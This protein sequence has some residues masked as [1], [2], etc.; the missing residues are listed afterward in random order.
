MSDARFLDICVATKCGESSNPW[1][2]VGAGRRC[3]LTSA[4]CCRSA[5]A[6]RRMS[7]LHGRA[8][9]PRS[10]SA[11]RYAHERP[12]DPMGMMLH[13]FR[14]R[15]K[16]SE[17]SKWAGLYDYP[18]EVELIAG[19]VARSRSRGYLTREDFLDIAEWKSARPRKH[20]QANQPAFI[21]EFSRL[22]FAPSASPRLAIEP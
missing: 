16:R 15:F 10:R 17:I 8:A 3:H 11:M 19:P 5:A 1:L 9:A 18:G 13:R 14:P 2:L 22:A 6:N 12:L 20:Y 21:E 7:N 4:C